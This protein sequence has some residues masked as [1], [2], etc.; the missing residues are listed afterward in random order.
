MADRRLNIGCGFKHLDGYVNVDAWAGCEP[1][2]QFT[3]D[4]DVWPF[5]D[6]SAAAVMF[7][8]SMEHM[9][10]TA[11]AFRHLVQE[12]YRVCA[13]GARVDVIVPHW[14]HDSFSDDP[15][16]VRVITPGTL[17]MLDRNRNHQS[18]LAGDS[19]SK[20]G[21]M[22]EVDFEF[23]EGVFVRDMA[24]AASPILRSIE[25]GAAANAS[26]VTADMISLFN[27][28]AQ[29]IRMVLRT[30]KPARVFR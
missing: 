24:N 7:Q 17:R 19:E 13:D 28:V 25:R 16:H 20:L 18:R 1:D 21:F 22:W 27:N 10:E 30:R 23:V 4:A 2:V 29:E 11:G 3:A 6:S 12:L 15:T 8:H 14:R 26:Q 9:G 5:P